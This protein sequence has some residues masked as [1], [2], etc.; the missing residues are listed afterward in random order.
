MD[1]ATNHF[2]IALTLEP[3]NAG[4]LFNLAWTLA[5]QQDARYRNGA[6]AV[7][8]AER[9]CEVTGRNQAEALDVLGA[10]C[11][12]A[13]RFEEAIRA[14]QNALELAQD[15]KPPDLAQKIQERLRLYQDHRPY[16]E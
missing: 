15:A 6:E 2:R 3:D 12:E 8:L 11:A 1:E 7:R 16:R 9:L 5:T 10:A 14:G 4:A 13:G